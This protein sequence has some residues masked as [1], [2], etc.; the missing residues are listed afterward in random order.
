MEMRCAKYDIYTHSAATLPSFWCGSGACQHTEQRCSSNSAKPYNLASELRTHETMMQ[1]QLGETLQVGFRIANT[2]NN[3]AVPSR[4]NPTSWLQNCEHKKQRC[5]SNLA[6]PYN[7]DSE[8]RKLKNQ[9]THGYGSSK[10]TMR[11]RLHNIC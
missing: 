8:L 7:L 4:R 6:K 3:D 11:L 9:Y 5:S 10:K 1:F 2:Q